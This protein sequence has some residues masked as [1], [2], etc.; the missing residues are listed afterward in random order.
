MLNNN[1]GKVILTKDPYFTKI[2]QNTLNV[3]E[4]LDVYLLFVGWFIQNVLRD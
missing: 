1:Y 2:K 3:D 4:Q